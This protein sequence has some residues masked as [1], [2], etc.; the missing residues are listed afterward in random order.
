MSAAANPKAGVTRKRKGKN[1]ATAT[2]SRKSLRTAEDPPVSERDILLQFLSG[3]KDT[4]GL[5]QE[6]SAPF[7]PPI[8]VAKPCVRAT[9]VWSSGKIYMYLCEKTQKFS[10]YHRSL[11]QHRSLYDISDHRGGDTLRR[12]RENVQRC[13]SRIASGSYRWF[14]FG[15][16]QPNSTERSDAMMLLEQLDGELLY[17]GARVFR[18]RLP[19]GESAREF[20]SMNRIVSNT[21]VWKTWIRSETH[22]YVI[23]NVNKRFG[24]RRIPNEAVDQHNPIQL[25][26]SVFPEVELDPKTLKSFGRHRNDR[27]SEPY[28]ILRTARVCTQLR[29]HLPIEHYLDYDEIKGTDDSPSMLDNDQASKLLME[30]GMNWSEYD[31]PSVQYYAKTVRFNHKWRRLA[32]EAEAF[33]QEADR[34]KEKT[35]QQDEDDLRWINMLERDTAGRTSGGI[36]SSAAAAAAAAAGVSCLVCTGPIGIPFIM[37]CGHMVCCNCRES[38]FKRKQCPCNCPNT[39]HLTS[40]SVAESAAVASSASSSSSS[41]AVSTVM[42]S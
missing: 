40:T 33:R 31:S 19:N 39:A 28:Y 6:Y 8:T 20:Y 25:W 1:K 22:C 41:V 36:L 10:V 23:S 17:V 34:M 11:Y 14:A 18:F 38:V 4:V 42:R 13:M 15:H 35:E 27:P 5:V 37:S 7:D 30:A 12:N 29:P 9:S 24:I 16:D 3:C 21:I 2:A 26:Q 32:R